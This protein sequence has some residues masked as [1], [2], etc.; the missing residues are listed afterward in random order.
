MPVL[1]GGTY[2]LCEKF[3]TGIFDLDKL[4]DKAR[5]NAN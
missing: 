4:E 3:V 1:R 2:W 5:G